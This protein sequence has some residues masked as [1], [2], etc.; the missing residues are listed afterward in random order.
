MLSIKIIAFAVGGFF[1]ALF[2]I[3][4]TFPDMKK[5]KV[6]VYS[7]LVLVVPIILLVVGFLIETF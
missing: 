5:E 3:A 6:L 2:G 7:G 4:T 1:L